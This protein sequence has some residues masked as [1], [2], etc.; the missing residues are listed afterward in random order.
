MAELV[1]A[2]RARALPSVPHKKL[3]RTRRATT[4]AE[5]GAWELRD[6]RLTALLE[7][8]ALAHGLDPR[9]TPASA[10]V[11][12]YMEHA[13]GTWYVRGGIRELARAVYERCV[14]RRVEFRF[15]A[16]VARIV[17][18]DGR[19][20]GVE[21]ADGEVADADFVVAGVAPGALDALAPG[22]AL[23]GGDEV[24]PQRGHRAG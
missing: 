20:T 3:L 16:P 6:P 19:A 13:F 9:V 11:L 15:E 18:K 1:G 22:T 14:A 23:R 2:R 21:L 5:V 10:A 12:P 7:S 24:A 8:H 17:E 4:L